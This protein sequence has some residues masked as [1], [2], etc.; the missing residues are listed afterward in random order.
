MISKRQ[1][2]ASGGPKG[3]VDAVALGDRDSLLQPLG[4]AGHGSVPGLEAEPRSDR[5][6]P[7]VSGRFCEQHAVCT[8]SYTRTA[9]VWLPGALRGA[10]AY[11]RFSVSL[12]PRHRWRLLPVRVQTLTP[13]AVP[14]APVRP[15]PSNVHA[16]QR[17]SGA[18]SACL[19]RL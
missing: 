8:F 4:F 10:R 18:D 3:N 15:W 16:D 19:G 11:S 9:R 5:A 14:Q 13:V 17:N 2:G 7:L 6:L 1:S 12:I